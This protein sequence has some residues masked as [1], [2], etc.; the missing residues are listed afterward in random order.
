MNRTLE[1]LQF[2]GKRS[3]AKTRRASP[4]MIQRLPEQLLGIAAG[5]T[6]LACEKALREGALAPRIADKGPECTPQGRRTRMRLQ[7]WRRT[8]YF[9]GVGVGLCF[10]FFISAVWQ[11]KP[12]S[13]NIFYSAPMGWL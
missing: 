4:Q 5:R 2:A 10:C 11:R 1:F 6:R 13:A 7:S 3:P 12:A 8:E 9:D